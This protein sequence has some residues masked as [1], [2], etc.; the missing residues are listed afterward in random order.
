[1]SSNFDLTNN[2]AVTKL[3]ALFQR[4]LP[5]DYAQ[6][7][8]DPDAVYPAPA[9]VE[10][11]SESPYIHRIGMFYA[12]QQILQTLHQ[13]AE[14]IREGVRPSFPI[15]T[16]P[17]ADSNETDYY[18][19]SL[20]DEDYGSVLFMDHETADPYDDFKDGLIPLA[21]SFASWLPTLKLVPEDPDLDGEVVDPPS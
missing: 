3:E 4:S 1:M 17:I 7:L 13:D 2:E 19:I 16:M 20:R 6:W 8:V 18:L 12:A 15:G 11:P 14:M 21:G 9:E 5:A 10:I